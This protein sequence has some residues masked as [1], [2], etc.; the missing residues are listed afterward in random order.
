MTRYVFSSTIVVIIPGLLFI[1]AITSLV[2]GV[3]GGAILAILIHNDLIRD[4]NHK[5]IFIK[6]CFIGGLTGLL[7]WK[8]VWMF[9][10][11]NPPLSIDQSLFIYYSVTGVISA[12]IG[13]AWVTRKLL[14]DGKPMLKKD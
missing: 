11:L 6:G 4:I 12:S 5:I 13:G 7:L 3:V 14:K 9:E 1:G 10:P 8:I 2:P